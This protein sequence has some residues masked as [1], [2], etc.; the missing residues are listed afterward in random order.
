MSNNNTEYFLNVHED[1]TQAAKRFKELDRLAFDFGRVEGDDLKIK[2][3]SPEEHAYVMSMGYLY[4]MY[5]LGA[6]SKQ[7]CIEIK[8]R[9]IKEC[10]DIHNAMVCARHLHLRWVLCTKV[11][12]KEHKEL[13]EMVRNSDPRALGKALELLDMLS[14]SYIY[15]KLYQKTDTFDKQE[16][17]FD[18]ILKEAAEDI[19]HSEDDRAELKKVVAL[20]I[21][22]FSNNHTPNFFTNMTDEDIKFLLRGLPEKVRLTE[23]VITEL[24]PRT[25]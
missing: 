16:I 13:A 19:L 12:Y 20:I 15:T 4:A 23:E 1:M 17:L 7:R 5:R 9:M 18:D 25:K 24:M 2:S 8:R 6:V 11:Y 14:S 10:A 21:E 22:E 3:L